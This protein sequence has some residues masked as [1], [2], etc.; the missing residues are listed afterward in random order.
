MGR[1]EEALA[2]VLFHPSSYPAAT[3]ALITCTREESG[4]QGEPALA[5]DTRCISLSL[6]KKTLLFPTMWIH[7]QLRSANGVNPALCLKLVQVFPV[8]FKARMNEAK[9]NG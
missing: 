2:S 8:L 3:P 7:T 1:E 5:Q 9:G 4:R 6:H